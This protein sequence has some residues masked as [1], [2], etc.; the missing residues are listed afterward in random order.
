[1]YNINQVHWTIRSFNSYAT[2]TKP[3]RKP[4]HWT[5]GS[6]IT[7]KEILNHLTQNIYVLYTQQLGETNYYLYSL[8]HK[9]SGVQFQCWRKP[10]WT[11]EHGKETG[12]LYQFSLRVEY[13]FFVIDKA[14][15]CKI[16]HL[17]W[18]DCMSC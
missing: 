1:M 10:E 13:T 14:V 4:V 2:M 12:K 8:H 5:I 6:P 15:G 3:G 9:S 18:Q 11:T 16:T 17:R 7:I